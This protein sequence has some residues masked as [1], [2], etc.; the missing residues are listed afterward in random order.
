[1]KMGPAG[2]K[3]CLRAGANDLG[4]TLMDETITR[5][6]GAVHGHEM[7]PVTMESIIRSIERFPRQRDTLYRDVSPDRHRA[8]FGDAPHIDEL[9]TGGSRATVQNIHCSNHSMTLCS[10]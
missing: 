5:S 2:V 9:S 4:G 8:S 10:R 1:V 6:A 3:A 7:T